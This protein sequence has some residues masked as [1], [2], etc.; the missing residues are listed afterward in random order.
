MDAILP[1]K[2]YPRG[3]QWDG[4]G[5]NF[6]LFTENAE[7]VE[8]L[9]FDSPEAPE[10]DRT[11]TLPVKTASTWHGYIPGIG[12]GQ[13]YAYRVHGPYEPAKGHRF[14]PAKAL[15]DPYAKALAGDVRWDD[16]LFGYTV[17]DP[18][19]DLSF[20][21]RDS[22]AFIPKSVVVDRSFDW[23]GD[24]HLRTPWNE[25]V[26]YEAHVRGLTM[27]HPDLPEEIRGT[28]AA[29]GSEP[30]IRHLTELGITALEL[31]P[32]QQHVDDLV[33]LERG[34]SNYWGYNTIGFFA[35][36]F[37]YASRGSPGRQ[38]N[39]FRSMVKALHK[40]GIEVIM[41]V[42]Y[43]HTAEGNHLGPTLCFKGIDNASYYCLN[44]GD[45][46]YYMDF[47]GCGGC[48]NMSHPRVLQFIMDSLR[49][50]VIEMHVDGFRFDLAATLAREFYEID[51]LSTF[52]DV[53][54]QDP[55]LSHVKLIAEPWD[56]GPGGYQVGNFP[57]LWNEWNGMYRDT[58]RRFW[59]G[60]EGQLS[61][62]GY[63]LTGSSDLY[64]YSNRNPQASVN[65]ITCH[66]GFTL[67]D[68]VSY[69]GKHNEANGEENRDGANENFS[70]NCGV[71]G[72]VDDAVVNKLR[73][74]QMKNILATLFLSQG[75][76]MLFGGDEIGKTKQGN[77]NT[78]CQDNKLSW[79]QWKPDDEGRELL[80]FTRFLIALRKRHP[81]FRRK[82][83]FQGRKLSGRG[84]RDIH[85]FK[86][87]GKEMLVREWSHSFA[88]S[89]GMLLAGDGI[90]DIDIHGE[91]IV[92][93]SFLVLLN[94][95]WEPIEFRLPKSPTK[96][97][98]IP[99]LDTNIAGSGMAEHVVRESTSYKL[100]SRSLVLLRSPAGGVR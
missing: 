36:D 79:L 8:I 24:A 59:K 70:W 22:S 66:D 61:E 81:V 53:I 43:N 25:T 20:D 73:F 96:G 41:D 51:R 16:A 48:F 99:V 76:P 35:P 77:N 74:R 89:I 98:W 91:R 80:E 17:G 6:S 69:D 12:P 26:I 88:R 92:D 75:T 15:I 62:I 93:D 40:A 14:N 32:V 85:W 46:R 83:F 94:A 29:V 5:T 31:L 65:F 87:D 63:R 10:P 95:H 60:D 21:E 97:G 13:H 82:S 64:K 4:R 58:V 84:V 9:L 38:V 7:K 55:V 28:F 90:P 57:E 27:L 67:R 71:E 3:P 54:C 45:P 78:Y 11:I 2:P 19:A 39:E 33:L 42:V 68:L 18:G 72:P 44:P 30:V 56:L 23:E 49:Y 34:L 100:E 86:P 52:F 1:G 47:S 37:R 50:W